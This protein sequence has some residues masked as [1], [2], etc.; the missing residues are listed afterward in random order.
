V[1]QQP[2]FNKTAS[3]LRTAAVTNED[4]LHSP[5][6]FKEDVSIIGDGGEMTRAQSQPGFSEMSKIRQASVM[7]P[8]RI[9][10]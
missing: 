9:M 10:S 2:L 1:Q 6:K 7:E 4:L 5:T 3:H 8:N